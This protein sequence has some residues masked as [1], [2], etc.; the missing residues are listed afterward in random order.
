MQ[1]NKWFC[2]RCGKYL[3]DA[4]E[5]TAGNVRA[6]CKR[7]KSPVDIYIKQGGTKRGSGEKCA[8]KNPS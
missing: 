6:F 3:F 2:P 1:F 5:N 7:C 8:D 4:A